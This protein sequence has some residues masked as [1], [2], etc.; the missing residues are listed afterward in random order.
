MMK[1]YLPGM[2]AGFLL[3]TLVNLP[4]CAE[5][6]PQWLG[7]DGS[8]RVQ[9][10]GFLPDLDKYKI[11]WEKQIGL[12]YASI[13]VADGKAFAMG[14]NQEG[15]ETVYCLDA[16]SGKELWRRSYKAELLPR[17]HKGGPN[18]SPTIDGDRVFTLSKDGR[19]YSLSVADGSVNWEANL[20]DIFGI[21]VPSWGFA[22]SPV[23]H[24]GRIFVSSG[25]VAALDASNGEKL[26]VSSELYH[27]GYT[28][29][30]V[31]NNG[32][33]E[34]VAA[35]DGKGLSILTSR[36]GVEVARHPSKAQFDM[37]AT[38]PVI[39]EEGNQIFIAGN[40]TSELLAFD[41]A[42]LESKWKTREIKN[43]MN[44]SVIVGDVIYGIDG[45]QGSRNA[46]LVA[47]SLGSGELIWSRDGFGFG[48]TIGVGG[49]ILS[50]SETGE[51]AVSGIDKSAFKEFSRRKVLDSTCWTTPVFANQRIYVRNDL[52]HLIC[53]SKS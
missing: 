51:L 8:N 28:T 39:L 2:T 41:G 25:K 38:T 14:H 48:N 53:L 16:S 6:W 21:K 19:L 11:A 3:A 12:G 30:V 35:M 34:F 32:A 52:G 1:S 29:P 42:S 37:Q 24:D 46:R 45:K 36:D 23:L 20:V 17:M 10:E 31:F 4:V 44:N 5:D 47:V 43:A 22:S 18:A 15:N 27:P 26:W 9:G 33:T 50:L 49:H 7:P 40:M 13:T